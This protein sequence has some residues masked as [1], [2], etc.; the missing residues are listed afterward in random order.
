MVC[1]HQC[2]ARIGPSLLAGD[3][4]DLA[5]E[6]R[7][8]LDAGAD[9][10]HL[11]V[12][13]GHFVPNITWGPPVIKALRKHVPTAFFDCHMMV[14]HPEQWVGDI[15]AAGGNQYT[16]HL[17]ATADPRALIHQI[18]AAGMKV[19]LAL[20]PGTPAA[21]CFF[22]VDEVDVVLVMTVEPGFGG[23]PF[24]ADMMPK[25]EELRARYPSVDIEVDGGLGPLTI[26]QAARAGANMIVAG[27]S[28]FQGNP[29]EV[30]AIL[31]RS[32]E[33]HGNGCGTTTTT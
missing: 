16:F 10:L 11:D 9:Y 15:Q 3:L 7:R 12:M 8:V 17:E 21:A 30:I 2:A 14:A 20:K 22:L 29:A 4:A 25:I 23:Q 28:V 24:L 27:S 18:R 5:G 13:D 6:A 31:R 1:C 33:V 26:D 19:G 32:V